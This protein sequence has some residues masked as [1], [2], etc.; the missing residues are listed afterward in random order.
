MG[1]QSVLRSTANSREDFLD[2]FKISFLTILCFFEVFGRFRGYRKVREACRKNFHLVAPLKTSVARF[3]DKKNKK[4][5][6]RST[7]RLL[8]FER[9]R[10]KDMRVLML[11]GAIRCSAV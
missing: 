6:R 5:L 10:T 7:P 8:K 2:F 3:Y 1:F 11:K 4:T 9:R